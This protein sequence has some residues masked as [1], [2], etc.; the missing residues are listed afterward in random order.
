MI[1]GGRNDTVRLQGTQVSSAAFP[2]LGVPASLGRTL[3]TTDDEP[4]AAPVVVLG[5]AVWTELFGRDPDIV[6]RTVRLDDTE[7]TVVGVMPPGF[8]LPDASFPNIA[9]QVWVPFSA[10]RLPPGAKASR[11]AI[12]RVKDGITL[13]AAAAEVNAMLPPAPN[14]RPTS[15]PR[16]ELVR[17]QDWLVGPVAQPMVVVVKTGLG[18]GKHAVGAVTSPMM[19]LATA[20]N[21]RPGSL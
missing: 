20:L 4:G 16:F 17:V 14:N 8:T 9:T 6:G 21:V 15:S 5:H 13:E 3:D 2:M 19:L 1:L 12:G 10:P 18:L 7:R 11:P